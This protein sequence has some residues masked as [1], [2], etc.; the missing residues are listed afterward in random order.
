[1]S[2][3]LLTLL[4][5]SSASYHCAMRREIAPCTCRLQ[6]PNLDAIK[7]NCEQMTYSSIAEALHNRF[8]P[9]Q[10]ITLTIS[11]S[12][13]GD[14]ENRTFKEMGMTISNLKL[15]YNELR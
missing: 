2:T 10:N 9:K 4:G 12:Q 8:P 7:V 5:L 6:E 3:F 15:N 11:Y 14:M 1:M 13:L